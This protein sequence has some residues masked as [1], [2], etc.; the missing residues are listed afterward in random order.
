MPSGTTSLTGDRYRALGGGITLLPCATA[1]A[2]PAS[3]EGE[4]ITSHQQLE[5][6]AFTIGDVCRVSRSIAVGRFTIGFT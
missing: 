6:T 4:G 3:E 1:Y 2:L 5:I